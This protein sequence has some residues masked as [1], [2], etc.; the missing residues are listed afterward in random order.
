MSRSGLKHIFVGGESGMVFVWKKAGFLLHGSNPDV[1]VV[2]EVIIGF[3]HKRSGVD[4]GHF[5]AYC[6]FR[7][8][9]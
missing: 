5:F 4:P 7:Q 1:E 6:K 8:A 2:G 3:M 9:Y